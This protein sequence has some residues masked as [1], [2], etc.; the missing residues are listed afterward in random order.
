[1]LELSGMCTQIHSEQV[2]CVT[3]TSTISCANRDRGRIPVRFQ[4][5]AVSVMADAFN[6]KAD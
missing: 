1:M 3:Q 5:I 2:Q 6:T 4:G